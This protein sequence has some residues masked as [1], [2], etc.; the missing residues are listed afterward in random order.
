[1]ESERRIFNQLLQKK[2]PE[3]G[4]T[5]MPIVATVLVLFTV[6]SGYHAISRSFRDTVTDF[7]SA[8][9]HRAP[10]SHGQRYQ[11]MV[12]SPGEGLENVIFIAT[13]SLACCIGS[14]V[15]TMVCE[16]SRESVAT[17]M[18]LAAITGVVALAGLVGGSRDFIA[19]CALPVAVFAALGGA[20]GGAVA[21]R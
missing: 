3:T 15:L 20:T 19:V 21:N 16:G 6:W 1:M 5:L 14:F 4:H 8:T 17:V 12:G 10:D 11:E 2:T 7:G 9:S 18:A 13:I